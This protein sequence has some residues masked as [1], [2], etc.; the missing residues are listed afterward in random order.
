VDLPKPAI[1]DGPIQTE[2]REARIEFLRRLLPHWQ[3]ELGLR[4]VLDLGCGVGYFS[5]MLQELGFQVVGIDGREENIA[6]ARE[7]FP[8]IDFRVADAEDPALIALGKFDFVLCFGLLYHL[9]NPFR[10]FRN[11]HALTS[12]LLLV[13]SMAV[14]DEKPFLVLLD[15]ASIEDQ[16][17]GGISCYP[18]EGALI[19]MAYRSGFAHVYRFRESPDQADFRRG[20]GRG[21]IRTMLAMS[22]KHLDS[23][24]LE[25][26]SEPRLS[27]DLWN[28]DP[29]GIATTLRRIGRKLRSRSSRKHT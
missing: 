22:A 13:E 17:L 20:I 10:A 4:T 27:G 11:L 14:T 8:A 23:P 9:E 18:T 12:K 6:Q 15:E 16:S 1:F 3:S 7:R 2:F 5:A 19:K 29:T 25:A 24:V 26:A 21:R 28:T